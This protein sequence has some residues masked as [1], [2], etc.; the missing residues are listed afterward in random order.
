M[1]AEAGKLIIGCGYLGRRVAARWLAQG[2]RVFATTRSAAKAQEFARLGMDPVLCDV[3]DCNSL[4][5]LPRVGVVLYCIG[6]DRSTGRPMRDVYVTGVANVLGALLSARRLVYVSSASVYGQEHG[7]E[8]DETAATEPVDESGRVVLE[9][10]NLV[11]G[12]CPSAIVLRFAGIYGPGRLLRQQTIELGE[13]IVGDPERWLNLIH[14]E[15][16]V[17]T[18]L[19]AEEHGK[20]GGTYNVADDQPVRRREFYSALAR[21]IGGPAPRFHMPAPGS[22]RSNHERANR[23]IVSRLLHVELRVQLEYPT[24]EAGLPASVGLA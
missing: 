18:V 4:S 16:G 17:T 21:L 22:P 23:R 7:E 24:Y 10:E 12:R 2:Q 6:H 20:P 1:D 14:V 11:R 9:A 19:A 3:L 13:P 5:S 8:V 15:D